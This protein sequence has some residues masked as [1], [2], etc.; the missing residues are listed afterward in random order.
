MLA[1]TSPT[2][3]QSRRRW[4]QEALLRLIDVAYQRGDAPQ[5]E[6]HEQD[7]NDGSPQEQPEHTSRNPKY[8]AH[9]APCHVSAG[10]ID[11]TIILIHDGHS[12]EYADIRTPHKLVL[13][14]T[15]SSSRPLELLCGCID[16][17]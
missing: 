3:E 10:M 5:H 14:C 4:I 11:E 16:A 7:V 13:L 6:Y 1:N 2:F 12:G 17:E 15:S 9:H 8:Q